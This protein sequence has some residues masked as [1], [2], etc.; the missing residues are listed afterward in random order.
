MQNFKSSKSMKNSI[1]GEYFIYKNQRRKR[2]MIK[3]LY[4]HSKKELKKEIEILKT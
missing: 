3:K 1:N 4:F 2:L